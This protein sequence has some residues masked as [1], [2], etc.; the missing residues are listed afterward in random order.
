MPNRK[1]KPEQK[2][3]NELTTEEAIHKLF[4]E[5]VIEYAKKIAHEKDKV[6][7]SRQEKS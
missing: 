6:E 5:E 4:P 1:P 3:D 7:E 2:P